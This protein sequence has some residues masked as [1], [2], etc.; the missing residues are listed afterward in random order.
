MCVSHPFFNCFFSYFRDVTD[1]FVMNVISIPYFL[2]F[3]NFRHSIFFF[4]SALRARLSKMY[5]HNLLFFKRLIMVI[6]SP[7][8][9]S[10][11]TD[12]RV[13]PFILS[14]PHSLAL[15]FVISP[16]YVY[17]FPFHLPVFTFYTHVFCPFPSIFFLIYILFPPE[18][19]YQNFHRKRNDF[20]RQG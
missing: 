2:R 3:Q 8:K 14:K 7:A 4:F 6:F 16:F 19:P 18:F 1:N 9:K 15:S 10:F 13:N 17:F 5:I 12:L 20:V 11:S